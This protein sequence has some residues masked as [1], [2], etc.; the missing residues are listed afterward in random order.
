MGNYQFIWRTLRRLGLPPDVA[1]DTA[2]QVFVIAAEKIDQIALGSERA[3]LFQTAIRGA[4]SV[5]RDLARKREVGDSELETLVDSILPPDEDLQERRHREY[6]DLVLA[7]MDDDLRMVFVL[8]EIEG[9]A[10]AEIAA[11][12]GVPMGTVAS[13][14]RRS[15]DQFHEAAVR[16]RARLQ[17]GDRP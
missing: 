10:T 7:G 9:L 11:L 8:F 15:R 5:R 2:Q 16:L 6:L 17:R 4:M 13:R 12:V 3:F 1:D 14:L